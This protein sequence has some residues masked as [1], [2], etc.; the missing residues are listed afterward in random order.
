MINETVRQLIERLKKMDQNAIV[1][2]IEIGDCDNP[3]YCTIEICDEYKN[4]VYQDDDGDIQKGNIVAF[5]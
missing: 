2:K 1:C 4:E 3:E 5:Y